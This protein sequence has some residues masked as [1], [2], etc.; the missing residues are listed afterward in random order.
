MVAESDEEQEPLIPNRGNQGSSSSSPGEADR[1]SGQHECSE[2]DGQKSLLQETLHAP[3]ALRDWYLLLL[4]EYG[5][6][7]LVLLFA[8]QHL[9]K[10][11]VNSLASESGRWIYKEYKVSGPRMQIFQGVVGMPWALKP[12]IGMVSD[13][14]PI[15]GYN[16]APYMVISSLLGVGAFVCMGVGHSASM[17]IEVAVACMFLINLQIS[18]CDLLTEAKYAEQLNQ[19]PHYGPDL[20][21]YVWSGINGGNILALLS[22]GWLIANLGPRMPYIIGAIPA[23]FILWPVMRNYLEETPQSDEDTSRTRE[24]LLQQGETFFLC[25]IMFFSTVFLTVIGMATES[26]LIHFLGA[27]VVGVTVLGS[28]CV[29]L[30]PMIAKINAFFLVQQTFGIAISGATFYFYT[31]SPTQ[32]PD[33]PHFSVQFFTTVLGLVGAFCSLVGLVIY[34]KYLKECTYRSLLLISNVLI[35]ILSMADILLFTRYNKKMGIPD[36][37]FVLGS[38]ISAT[39][40]A[41]WQWMPGIVILSQLCPKGMEATMYALLA[42]CHNLGSTLSEYM[43]AYVLHL[44]DVRPSGKDNESHEFDNLWKAAVISTVLPML[45]LVL[46]PVLIPDARQTDKLLEEEDRSATTGSLWS[47]WRGNSSAEP[48]T[49]SA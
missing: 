28:F 23:A 36:T 33:G 37:Y 44:L 7:L 14:L 1:S 31:D 35:A 20:M 29:L 27:L 42:G 41:Q 16:K 11:V 15:M 18:V 6:K 38:Q 43:G 10:G 46:L 39:V 3:V 22:I 47:R 45:T 9:M 12:I 24:E 8:S 17:P 49:S 30:R 40:I 4:N 26:H 5:Y 21:T 48:M 34:N 2:K 32:Y 13:L 25:L 19:K